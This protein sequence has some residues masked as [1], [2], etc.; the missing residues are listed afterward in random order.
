MLRRVIHDHSVSLVFSVATLQ[1]ENEPASVAQLDAPL[2][3]H[4]EV[5]GSTPSGLATYFHG[6]MAM[7]YFLWSFCPSTYSRRVVIST[8]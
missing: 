7:K 5:A 4:Q 3:G 6:D 1:A 8:G 2:I